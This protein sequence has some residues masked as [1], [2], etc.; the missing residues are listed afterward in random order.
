MW[1]EKGVPGGWKR[2]I[3]Y[4]N[5]EY[6]QLVQRVRELAERLDVSAVD[7]ERV[8]W[9]LGHEGV[10]VEKGNDEGK[11][12]TPAKRTQS[13]EADS[14]KV[15]KKSMPA[16]KV[17]EPQKGVKRKAGETKPPIEGTRRSSRRKTET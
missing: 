2:I 12:A 4:N 5:K 16:T 10:D 11:K 6:E 8:A 3:K 17:K 9:V 14:K 7:A 15:I 13:S 1:D